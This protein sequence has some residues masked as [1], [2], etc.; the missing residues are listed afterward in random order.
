M[1]SPEPVSIKESVGEA[2]HFVRA[3]WRFV[4]V[5]AALGAGALVVASL[6]G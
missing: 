4:M 1:T 2:L 6:L 3:Q 5:V